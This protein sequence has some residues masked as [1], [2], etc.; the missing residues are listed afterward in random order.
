ML[1]TSYFGTLKVD[2]LT[3]P[4]AIAAV[5]PDLARLRIAIFREFPYLYDGSLDYETDY[6]KLY[7]T[8]PGAIVVTAR[9]Q[10][11]EG[12]AR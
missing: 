6:L 7:A 5:I 8:T 4:D 1:P 12:S 2:S 9:D 10:A 3:D 11:A